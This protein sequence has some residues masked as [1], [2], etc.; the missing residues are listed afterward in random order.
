[1]QLTDP[2]LFIGSYARM[3]PRDGNKHFGRGR[4]VRIA[5]KFGIVQPLQRHRQLHR[6]P[7]ADLHTWTAGNIARRETTLSDTQHT[8]GA[9]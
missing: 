7:L 4:L 6:V 3:R 2:R 9:Q 5:G 1:M 8:E